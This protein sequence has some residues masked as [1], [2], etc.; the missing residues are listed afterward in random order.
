MSGKSGRAAKAGETV[1]V[2]E[3]EVLLRLTIAAYLRTAA[4]R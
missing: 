3:G 4:T 1:L 2:I